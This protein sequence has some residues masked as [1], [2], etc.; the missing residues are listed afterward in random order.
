MLPSLSPCP[1]PDSQIHDIEDLKTSC[2]KAKVCPYFTA[3]DL[4]LGAE[5][6][7]C[8]Y[9]CCPYLIALT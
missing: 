8:P 7:F 4:A 1:V 9:R 3:R 6:I 2:S 5:L